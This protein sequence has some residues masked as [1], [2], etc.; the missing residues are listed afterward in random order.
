MLF[1]SERTLQDAVWRYRTGDRGQVRKDV[2][3]LYDE[4]YRTYGGRTIDQLKDAHPILRNPAA[5]HAARNATNV[6]EFS[7]ALTT[8]AVEKLRDLEFV[9][10]NLRR[11]PDVVFRWDVVVKATLGE[12]ELKEDSVFAQLIAEQRGKPGS[13]LSEKALLA[14]CGKALLFALA[15]VSLPVGLTVAVARAGYDTGAAAIDY[16]EQMRASEAG[17]REEPSITPVI[18]APAARLAPYVV[19]GV[20]RKFPGAP[21]LEKGAQRRRS[22]RSRRA[23][24]EPSPLRSTG[25]R[26]RRSSSPP[27]RWPKRHSAKPSRRR[28]AGSTEAKLSCARSSSPQSPSRRES[29]RRRRWRPL[30]ARSRRS[31]P[32]SSPPRVTW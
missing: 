8:Y 7:T 15:F 16:S 17:F 10:N 4:L 28:A 24:S 3:A 23:R 12:L 25:R 30:R 20:V 26:P 18:T 6:V 14:R 5:L 13:P 11:E 32:A 27:P 29:S 22:R 19:L 9:K 1:E 2:E 31:T 21:A